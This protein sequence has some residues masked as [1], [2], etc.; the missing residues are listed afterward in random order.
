MTTYTTTENGHE[1]KVSCW[2]GKCLNFSIHI[3]GEPFDFSVSNDDI[4]AETEA[5]EAR[6][7]ALSVVDAMAEGRIAQ[8]NGVWQYMEAN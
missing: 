1:I 7:Q 8:V 5:I 6:D 3:D 2:Q 4:N